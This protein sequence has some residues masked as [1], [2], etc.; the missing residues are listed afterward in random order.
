[1]DVQPLSTDR[2]VSEAL[3]LL[4]EEGLAKVTLRKL[5]ERLNVQAMSLY[6]HIRNKQDLQRRM[7]TAVFTDCLNSIPECAS[8][9][10]WL[11][12]FGLELWRAHHEVRDAAMLIF[13][14][15]QSAA[16]LQELADRITAPLMA[17]GLEAS[18]AVKIQSSVQAM[19]IGWTGVD[20]SFGEELEQVV[21]VK[22]TMEE[23]LDALIAGWETLIERQSPSAPNNATAGIPLLS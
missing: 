7:S 3:A 6:W 17:L 16:T 2:I 4:A 18:D 9:Q 21:R 22:A 14:A 8:W 11:K 1:M 10:M 15:G 20:Q 5:A 13:G 23:S 19:M 12:A